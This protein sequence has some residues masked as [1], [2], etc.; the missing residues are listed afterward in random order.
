MK[1][2]FKILAGC[3]DIGGCNAIYPV[4]RKL[5]ASG[6]KV[7]LFASGHSARI[8]RRKGK[9][10][11]EVKRSDFGNVRAIF[12]RVRPDAVLLGTSLGFSLE[13]ALVREGRK[14]KIKTIAVFDSWVNYSLRFADPANKK[15]LYYL[16]DFICVSDNFTRAQ[17]QKE[18]IPE[19]KIVVTGNPNFDDL[20]K[21]AKKYTLQERSKF[22][23]YYKS[24]ADT[25]V[26][27][28]FSQGIDKTFGAGP[29]NKNFLGYTQFEALEVLI[30]ALKRFYSGKKALLII[31]PHPKEEAEN[32]ARFNSNNGYLRVVVSGKEDPRKVIAMSDIVCGMFSLMLVE[33]YLLGKKILSIQPN[34][35]VENPL[36]LARLGLIKSL[37]NEREIFRQLELFMKNN[38][39]TGIK[40]FLKIGKSTRNVIK[41]ISKAIQSQ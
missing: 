23:K 3:Q 40:S 21:A 37:G 2:R 13:D 16:P 33:A 17:M 8:L 12:N 25:A 39:K 28:F 32:Y 36:I 10:F 15:S 14:R 29:R 5:R 24:G 30:P 31:R 38:G 18:R 22:I 27:S 41:L 9:D 11:R 34:L 6:H 4:V 35:R 19:E 1:N 20:D 7:S 26:I